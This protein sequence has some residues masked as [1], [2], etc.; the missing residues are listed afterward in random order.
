MPPI[1][2]VTIDTEEEF[3]WEA[4][5]S[6]ANRGVTH[7]SRL[8]R[9]QDLFD[10]VGARATYVVDHPVATNDQ[11]IEVLRGFLKRG[12]CEVGAHIHPWV[13]PP[14]EEEVSARNSFLCNL[15]Q[16]LQR[17]KI[18]EL[19]RA[20]T[21]AFDEAPTTFKAGRY[22]LD[23]E[24]AGYLS[25]LGYTADNSV[26]AYMD[27]SSYHGPDY[28]RVSHEPYWLIPPDNSANG[29]GH[30]LLEIPCTVGFTR[31]PFQKWSRVHHTFANTRLN[32]L[33][34]IGVMWHLGI[35]RKTPLTPE[36]TEVTDL[37]RLVDV[38]ASENDV[39]LNVTLHSP[40]IAPGHTPYVR[41]EQE[42][43]EFLSRLKNVLQH[44]IKRYDAR[45]LTLREFAQHQ[46]SKH[47]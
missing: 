33:R 46:R 25:K 21:D 47:T 18:D 8:E 16:P 28:S 10:E 35:L 37:L 9:L 36:G 22:G 5:F 13:N 29:D 45:C 11:S 15:P 30:G 32:A 2:L 1:L 6:S 41:S 40:S 17:Q 39:I 43:D 20:I 26:I 7:F 12:T 38:M 44:A 14:I 23:F 34:L 3:D 24:L 4:D 27:F 42:L 31:R 19:T